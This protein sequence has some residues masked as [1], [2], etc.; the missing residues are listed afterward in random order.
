MQ[1]F[2]KD[3]MNT[4]EMS[5]MG[6][7]HYFLGMEVHHSTEGIFIS[8]RKYAENI[9]KKIKM[10]NYKSVTTPCCQ[11]KSKRQEM[12]LIKQIQQFTEAWLEVYYI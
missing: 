9:V 4:Y 8:Q 10:D 3:M 7:L 6:L 2:K 12:V 1:Y 5:D 11:M